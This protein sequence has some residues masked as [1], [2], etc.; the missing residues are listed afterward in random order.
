[1]THTL[2]QFLIQKNFTKGKI[3]TTL[4]T[5]KFEYH[6]LLVQIYVD[7]II[8]SSTN[9]DLCSK[10]SKLMQ[11]KFEVNIISDL[12][13]FLILQVKQMK[14]FSPTKPST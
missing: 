4:F 1:M 5:I 3:D 6:T 12:N 11:N 10:F 9:E 7:D 2:S 13:F 14:E 8:F